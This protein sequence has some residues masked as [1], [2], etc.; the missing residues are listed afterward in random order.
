VKYRLP[1][2]FKSRQPVPA[3][4]SL[5]SSPLVLLTGGTTV[6]DLFGPMSGRQ[7]GLILPLRARP[8]L[9]CTD[10]HRVI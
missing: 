5:V 4:F 2:V 6:A 9:F 10:R 8:C 3:E 7:K 1:N